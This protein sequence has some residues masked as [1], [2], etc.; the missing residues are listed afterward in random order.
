[1]TATLDDDFTCEA[2]FLWRAAAIGTQVL[3]GL[4]REPDQITHTT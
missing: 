2:T 4:R 3:F 1:M